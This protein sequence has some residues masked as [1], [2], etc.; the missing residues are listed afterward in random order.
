MST[1]YDVVGVI[2][3]FVEVLGLILFGVAAGWFT[4]HMINQPEK[5]WQLL[6]I[7]F[8]VFLVF[9]ALMVKYLTPGAFGAYLAGAAG[10]MIFWGLIKTREKPEKKK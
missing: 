10:A 1:F 5:N 9:S 7:V 6:S 4:L 8:S 2:G 3:L